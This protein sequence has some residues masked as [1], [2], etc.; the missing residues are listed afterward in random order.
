MWSLNVVVLVASPLDLK[1]VLAIS[2]EVLQY[3]GHD[4]EFLLKRS[5]REVMKKQ[6]K[7]NSLRSCEWS[8]EQS[9]CWLNAKWQYEGGNTQTK[10]TAE[11]GKTRHRWVQLKQSGQREPE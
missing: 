6:T 7:Q 1:A 5:E 2:G 9:A 10:Y 8:K 3:P 11:E 4:T